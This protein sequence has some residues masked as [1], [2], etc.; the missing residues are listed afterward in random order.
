MASTDIQ[1]HASPASGDVKLS[2]NGKTEI[3]NPPVDFSK[4]RL[5]HEVFRHRAEDPLQ[6]PIMAFPKHEHHDFEYFTA[7]DLDA[8]TNRAAWLYEVR[9]LQVVSCTR[10]FQADHTFRGFSNFH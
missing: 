8:C 10:P 4:F 5:L 6:T 9:G 7:K 1:E 2:Q 3:V